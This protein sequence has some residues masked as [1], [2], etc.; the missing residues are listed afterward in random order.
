MLSLLIVV[1][2]GLC[3]TA[4][5]YAS[6]VLSAL[7]G[8]EGWGLRAPLPACM[9]LSASAALTPYSLVWSFGLSYQHL[10]MALLLLEHMVLQLFPTFG[11]LFLS[12]TFYVHAKTLLTQRMLAIASSNLPAPPLR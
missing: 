4:F 12:G 7:K 6:D 8:R 3:F 5:K 2:L 11:C 1:I 10:L 9:M